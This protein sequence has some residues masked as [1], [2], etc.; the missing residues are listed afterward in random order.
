MIFINL[1]YVWFFLCHP[2]IISSVSDETKK[3]TPEELYIHRCFPKSA[4]SLQPEDLSIASKNLENQKNKIDENFE[5]VLPKRTPEP[6]LLE[7]NSPDRN[8]VVLHQSTCQHHPAGLSNSI[9]KS[10]AQTSSGEMINCRRLH[11]GKPQSKYNSHNF[12]FYIDKLI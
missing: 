7:K 10:N 6:N 1:N 9:K 8:P 11:D 2:D 5:I 12:P 3:Q 4:L